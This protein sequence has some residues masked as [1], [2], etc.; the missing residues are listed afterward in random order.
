MQSLRDEDV[1]KREDIGFVPSEEFLQ[2]LEKLEN[3]FERRPQVEQRQFQAI[4]RLRH[5]S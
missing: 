4:F 2:E 1:R 3:L 5:A